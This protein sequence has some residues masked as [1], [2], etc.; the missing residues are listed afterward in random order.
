[1][2]VGNLTVWWNDVRSVVPGALGVYVTGDP[3][4]PDYFH[5]EC[6]WWDDASGPFD[7]TDPGSG[8][9]DWNPFGL[10]QPV[11]DYFHYKA[12]GLGGVDYW[13]DTESR[14]E[15]ECAP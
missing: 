9:P 1:V 3:P 14:F 11:S 7:P 4:G 8:P 15:T 5:A 6:N 10:G 2:G 12:D 13:L